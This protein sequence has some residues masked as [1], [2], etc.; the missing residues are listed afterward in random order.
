[1]KIHLFQ[2]R[3]N[4]HIFPGRLGTRC[5]LPN[6]RGHISEFLLLSDAVLYCFKHH[7]VTSGKDHYMCSSQEFWDCPSASTPYTPLWVPCGKWR[8]DGRLCWVLSTCAVWQ[9]RNHPE[10]YAHPHQEQHVWC[11]THASGKFCRLQCFFCFNI[12]L[13]ETVHL[14]KLQFFEKF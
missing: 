12:L 11:I 13:K 2:C 3:S 4:E 8:E 5:P 14:R 10:S 7:A 6:Y 1:M 9:R